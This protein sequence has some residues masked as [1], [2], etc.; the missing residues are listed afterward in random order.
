MIRAVSALTGAGQRLHHRLPG[1]SI[2][3]TAADGTAVE[4][5][6]IKV[7]Q[8]IVKMEEWEEFA[9]EQRKKPVSAVEAKYGGGGH[10]GIC[11][12]GGLFELET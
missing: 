8:N 10:R 3:R 12:C 11:V 6:R 2:G 1:R 9:H 4:E 7:E 5:N